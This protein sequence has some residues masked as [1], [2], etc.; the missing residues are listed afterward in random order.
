V[1]DRRAWLAEWCPDCRAAP[2]AR[3]R[4]HS[5]K[6]RKDSARRLHFARGWR[7]R[8]CPT[9]R[10]LLDEMCR[11]PSGREASRPHTA[12]LRRGRLELVGDEVWEELERRAATVAIVPFSGRAGAGGRTGTITLGRLEGDELVEVER[13]SGGRDELGYALEAPVWDRFGGFAGQPQVRGTVTWMLAER[14]VVIEG[15]RRDAAFEEDLS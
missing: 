11:T 12:R 1:S 6:K 4:Q 7:Y 5:I 3:C 8:S 14:R 13:W 10:A 2:G 9:C 15:Q